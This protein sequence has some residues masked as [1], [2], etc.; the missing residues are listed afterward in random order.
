MSINLISTLKG[1]LLEGFFPE[2]WDLAKID[3]C[4]DHAPECIL[5]RQ[6]WWHEAFE[7]VP[8]ASLADFDTMMGHE[9]AFEIKAAREAGREIVFI[10]PVGPMGMY[11]WAVYFLTQWGVQCDH[12]YGFNMDE[13]SDAEGNTLPADD[14]GAFQHAMEDALYRRIGIS[15]RRSICPPIRSRSAR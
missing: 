5:D 4:C 7:P 14:P 2:G 9:I 15:P 1:S 6:S 12:V 13:W 10:L 11:K 8:C 3:R